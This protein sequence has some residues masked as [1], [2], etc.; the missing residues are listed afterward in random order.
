M[1]IAILQHINS[2]G[3]QFRCCLDRTI[4]QP[5][6]AQWTFFTQTFS[7]PKVVGTIA[8]SFRFAARKMIRKVS[9]DPNKNR[10]ILEV[11]AGTGAITKHLIKELKEGDHL[12]VVECLPEM[13]KILAKVIEQS[14]KSQQV[15]LHEMPIQN[16][17]VNKRKYDYIV[18]TLPLNTFSPDQVQNFYRQVDQQLLVKNGCLSYIEL[19]G[20]PTI[21]LVSQKI[22]SLY[23]AEPYRRFRFIMNTK[24]DY[25]IGKTVEQDIVLVNF[26]PARVTHVQKT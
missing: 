21:R 12:D 14:G 6:Q 3:N 25:L 18:S 22:F 26:P 20:L 2:F 19:M 7:H 11:G 23:N 15:T 17:K 5:V 16:F 13:T 8:P 4:N 10:W 24:Q 1:A 9:E